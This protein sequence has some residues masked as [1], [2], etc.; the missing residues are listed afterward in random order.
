MP[1]NS[2]FDY[3]LTTTIQNYAQKQL[4]DNIFTARPLT[5]YLTEKNRLRYEDGG[6]KVIEPLIYADNGTA[7]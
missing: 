1:G 5:W 7:A 2:N 6:S 4:T 3:L